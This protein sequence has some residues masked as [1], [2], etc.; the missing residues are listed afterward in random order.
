[1]LHLNVR[2]NVAVKILEKLKKHFLCFII[3]QALK[4][5]EKLCTRGK[6]VIDLNVR[7]LYTG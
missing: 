6:K 1:M 4:Q 5:N 7:F 3:F 2:L